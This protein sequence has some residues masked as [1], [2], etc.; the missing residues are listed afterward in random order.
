M[1][2]EPTIA[3]RHGP[4][5]FSDCQLAAK[6]REGSG[7]GGN[8]SDNVV[9][10]CILGVLSLAYVLSFLDPTLDLSVVVRRGLCGAVVVVLRRSLQAMMTASHRLPSCSVWCLQF[11]MTCVT[12]ACSYAFVASGPVG[13]EVSK[14]FVMGA[15]LYCWVLVDTIIM[16]RMPWSVRC[17]FAAGLC[18]ASGSIVCYWLPLH[19]PGDVLE[20]VAIVVILHILMLNV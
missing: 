20:T 8:S 18:V 2:F 10:G 4:K 17:G 11:A 3:T 9:P 15:V 14:R 13:E 7:S 16:Q 6:A 19:T 5:K 12:A 1:L